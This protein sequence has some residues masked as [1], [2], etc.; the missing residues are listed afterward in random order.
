[1]GGQTPHQPAGPHVPQEDGLV[2]APTSKNIS[3]GREGETVDVVMVAQKRL[4]PHGS[5]RDS[6]PKSN[7]LVVGTRGQS[8]AIGRPGDGG[9]AR[10]VADEGLH[11]SAGADFPYPYGGIGG[12]GCDPPSV[13]GYADL[14]Y[15]FLVSN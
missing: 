5:A 9:D 4:R 8:P 10:H 15:R 2:V 12:G 14:R 3:L 11:V 6:I 1:M 13:G 7:G